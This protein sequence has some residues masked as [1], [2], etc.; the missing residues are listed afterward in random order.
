MIVNKQK[1]LVMI[2]VLTLMYI[3][4]CIHFLL[5]NMWYLICYLILTITEIHFFKWKWFLILVALFFSFR[6]DHLVLI[7]IPKKLFM[8]Y[9]DK[10][11]ITSFW[12]FFEEWEIWSFVWYL[13]LP[14]ILSSYYNCKN[15][16]FELFI[17]SFSGLSF[18]K[19]NSS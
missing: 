10:I 17:I 18:N 8:K 13:F 15:E 5:K 14:N 19:S 1:V 2:Y 4:L 11:P 3:V 6:L 7:F 16:R 9:H 12:V